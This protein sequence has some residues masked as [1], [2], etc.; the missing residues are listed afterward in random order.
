MKNTLL[1]AINIYKSYGG[2]ERNKVLNNAS[3]VLYEGDFTVIMGASGAGKSTMLY[4]ISGMDS[5]D[6]GEV[7]YQGKEIHALSEKQTAQLRSRDFGFVFQ[8]GNL[9]SNLSLWEN[10]VVAGVKALGK[11]EAAKRADKLISQMSLEHAKDRLPGNVSGGEAQRA[12]L[13]RGV[14]TNPAILFADE[15]TGALNKRNT[16]E[17]LGLLTE[18]NRKGQSIVLVTHDVRAAL[19]GNRI[20]YMEDGAMIAEK[21]LPPYDPTQAKSREQ[22]LNAWLSDMEW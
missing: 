10:I 11:A 15:P 13:A 2:A 17:V 1:S 12:A 9:V 20:L 4:A 19:R 16:D 22:A 6:S 8:Q 7:F 5:I 21:E 14:I 3:L 18:L